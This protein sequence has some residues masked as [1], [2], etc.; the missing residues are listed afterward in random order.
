M[1][2]GFLSG[3]VAAGAAVSIWGIQLPIA[4]DAFV[5]LDP[6]HMT[7]IRYAVPA[8]IVVALLGATEG[9]RSLRYDGA[10][11]VAS[12][13]GVVGLCA[14]PMLVF[15]G[16][17]MSGAEHAAVIVALQPSIAALAI[18]WFHGIRPH[19]FTLACI[20]VAFTGVVL[21]VTRGEWHI[22][23]GR[24]AMT[25]DVI[26]FAGAACWVA[27]TMGTS[28]LAGWSV[29]RI[30]ALTLVPGA[31][32]TALVTEAMVRLGRIGRPT[33]SAI[34]SVGWE[35]AYLAFVGVV[36]AMLL[37]NFGNR[38]I[39]PQNATLLINLLPVATFAYRAA[40]GHR[41]A[42]VEITGAALVV[43]A[44]VANNLFVRTHHESG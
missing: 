17:S 19:P 33:I 41:F 12:A 15:V 42:P 37:W 28:R 25:G 8:A 6:F 39:G 22:T 23:S 7:L 4:K 30:T 34:T 16:M 43:T 32:A 18:W 5:V 13:L 29:W 9:S 31:V 11:A 14:S 1:N 35:L 10:F 27:Y 24:R 44:L 40:Q 38:R 26:A 36:A 3:L 2:R 20:A 21:V